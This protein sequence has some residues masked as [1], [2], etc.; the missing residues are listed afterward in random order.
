MRVATFGVSA[1]PALCGLSL[2]L[3]VGCL[4]LWNEPVWVVEDLSGKGVQLYAAPG[5]EVIDTLRARGGPRVTPLGFRGDHWEV[6]TASGLRGWLDPAL[7]PVPTLTSRFA[8]EHAIHVA[9]AFP[10]S[11]ANA[12]GELEPLLAILVDTLLDE[13]GLYTPALEREAAAIWSLYRPYSESA[14]RVW[15]TVLSADLDAARPLQSGD[16]D[17]FAHARR[18]RSL[19]AQRQAG[20]WGALGDCPPDAFPGR[21]RRTWIR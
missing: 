12:S 20:S 21:A 6:E 19:C 15:I 10:I 5:G 4:S 16:G 7:F 11:S 2:L 3:A 1:S 13:A 8:R 9:T 17:V 14:V 18:M